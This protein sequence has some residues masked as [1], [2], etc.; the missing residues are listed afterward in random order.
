[1]L[2]KEDRSAFSLDHKVAPPEFAEIRSDS[3]WAKK[4]GDLIKK[5]K[6]DKTTMVTYTI[7]IYYTPEVKKS[8][9]NIATMVENVVDQT[10]Q[11]YKNSKI[12]V[13]VKLHCMEETS[14]P[15]GTAQGTDQRLESLQQVQGWRQQPQGLG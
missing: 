4:V 15:I 13:R 14:V 8:V 10:N 3:A 12:P 1:V 9:K 7:K 6:T 5:G 2:I 11:G